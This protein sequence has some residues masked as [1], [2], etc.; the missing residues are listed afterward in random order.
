MLNPSSRK[1]V[2]LNEAQPFDFRPD[3][4]KKKTTDRCSSPR[5]LPAT[6]EKAPKKGTRKADQTLQDHPSPTA[7]QG[8][9]K[10]V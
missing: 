3:K 8:K 7:K 4:K 5:K 9:E 1:H 2:I 6:T 10:G